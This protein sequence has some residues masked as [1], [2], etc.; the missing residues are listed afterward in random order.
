MQLRLQQLLLGGHVVDVEF[1]HKAH[2]ACLENLA[3]T[4]AQANKGI[5]VEMGLMLLHHLRPKK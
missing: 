2:Q 3:M 5:P 1:L 4:E